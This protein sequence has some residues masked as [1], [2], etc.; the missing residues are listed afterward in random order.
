VSPSEQFPA[1]PELTSDEK[2]KYDFLIDNYKYG[3]ALNFNQACLFRKRLNA[4]N[5]LVNMLNGSSKRIEKAT[6]VL[7]AAT[8]VLLIVTL[9]SAFG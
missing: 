4:L 3:D 7:L 9:A 5:G 1:D 8:I 6:Y 2:E